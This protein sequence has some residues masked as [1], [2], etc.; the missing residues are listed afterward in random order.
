MRCD[1]S[2]SMVAAF[3]A[4][5]GLKSQCSEFSCGQ[6][7]CGASTADRSARPNGALQEAKKGTMITAC[8]YLSADA[9]LRLRRGGVSKNMGGFRNEIADLCNAICARAYA[10]L[11]LRSGAQG[12]RRRVDQAIA[13]G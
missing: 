4:G 11:R 5:Q 13:V 6:A 9:R 8:K 12:D 7:L 10:C 3:E 1:V 2:G